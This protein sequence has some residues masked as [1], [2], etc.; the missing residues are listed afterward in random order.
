MA[1]QQGSVSRSIA[2]L[3]S[4]E[5][6]VSAGDDVASLS[7]STSLTT[8]VRALRSARINTAQAESLLNVADS[9]MREIDSILQRMS[10][11]AVSSSSG[12]L[13]STERHFLDQEF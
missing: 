12:A 11:L 10:S 8:K 5:Q 9:G 4:G 6:L 7:I 1:R 3:S 2:R 13:T